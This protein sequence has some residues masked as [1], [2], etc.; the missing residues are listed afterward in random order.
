MT[1]QTKPLSQKAI[2]QAAALARYAE[3]AKKA[4]EARKQRDLKYKEIRAEVIRIITEEPLRILPG[5]VQAQVDCYE[6]VEN[7]IPHVST[8]I[9]VKATELLDTLLKEADDLNY[10]VSFPDFTTVKRMVTRELAGTT[11]SKLRKRKNPIDLDLVSRD[12]EFVKLLQNLYD[13]RYPLEATGGTTATEDTENR[14]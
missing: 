1:K 14:G 8:T 6:G 3:F 11:P 12:P 2:I 13:Y 10:K 7:P 4:E 5:S 9:R